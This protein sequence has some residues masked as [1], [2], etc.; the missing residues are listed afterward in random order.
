MKNGLNEK[1]KWTDDKYFNNQIL[2]TYNQIIFFSYVFCFD[3]IY[4]RIILKQIH[5]H[6]DVIIS[7]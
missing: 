6:I 2:D 7:T 5:A 4:G 3:H 1:I